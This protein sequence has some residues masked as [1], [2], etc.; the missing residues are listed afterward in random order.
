MHLDQIQSSTCII[1]SLKMD[2][3]DEV[4]VYSADAVEHCDTVHLNRGGLLLIAL[5]AG[6]DYQPEGFH[7]AGVGIAHQLAQCGYG[8]QLLQAALHASSE[9]NFHDRLKGWRQSIQHELAFNSSHQLTC[10]HPRLANE[11]AQNRGFPDYQT[12]NLYA[13]PLVSLVNTS[14]ASGLP[15]FHS[16]EPDVKTI[17]TFCSQRFGW[18]DPAARHARLKKNLWEGIC[19]RMLCS[20]CTSSNLSASRYSRNPSHWPSSI[21]GK[22]PS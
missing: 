8:N 4:L 20:V 17:S 6:G 13:N 1:Y 2:N 12:T 22:K 7:G 18:S 11:L 19:M 10:R 15:R 14:P 9:S 16:N 21:S 5:L 3:R